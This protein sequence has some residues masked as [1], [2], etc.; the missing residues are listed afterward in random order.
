[1]ADMDFLVEGEPK[2]V[3]NKAERH[4]LFRAG[5]TATGVSARTP[6][7]LTVSEPYGC[8]TFVF[9]PLVDVGRV[10]FLVEAVG[11]GRTR[12][13]VRANKQRLREL[14]QH[15]VTEELGG[16]PWTRD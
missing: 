10:V 8:V 6:T 12:L 5:L 4:M 15:W 3:L 16:V 13:T 14:V 9:G 1:M 2:E 11:E 7:T